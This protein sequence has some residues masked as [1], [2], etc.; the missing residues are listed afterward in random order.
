MRHAHLI[1]TW[2]DYADRLAAAEIEQHFGDRRYVKFT[3][4]YLDLLYNAEGS[5]WL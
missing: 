4:W 2:S 3:P 5:R 1:E